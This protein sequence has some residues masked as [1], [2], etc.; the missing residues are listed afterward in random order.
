MPNLFDSFS[1]KDLALRNRVVMP[2]MC[3]YSVTAK[4]GKP[5][6]WHF[7]HY[8]SRA[9]GGAGLIVMEMTDVHPDGR[10]TDNDLGIWSD[11]H[12]LA[13]ARIV[14]GVHSHGAKIGIQI[15]HAGRKAEDAAQPVAP[16][17]IVYPDPK[18]N[19]PR[20]LSTEEVKEMVQLFADAA[21]RAV[22]AGV[23][24]IE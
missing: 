14:D 6:D 15:A 3:Q 24:T 11:E 4:D 8:L 21:R 1:F 10:I 18:Y 13:F 12:I 17:A 7:V 19:M 9:I 23:D 20:A 22:E 5:N 16:S 2:P